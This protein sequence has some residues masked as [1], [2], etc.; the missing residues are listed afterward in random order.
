VSQLCTEYIRVDS[1]AAETTRQH[2]EAG[3]LFNNLTEEPAMAVNVSPGRFIPF[4]QHERGVGVKAI[5][6]GNSMVIGTQQ[7]GEI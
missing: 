1:V 2:V 5:Y 6:I 7:T 3:R 4:L